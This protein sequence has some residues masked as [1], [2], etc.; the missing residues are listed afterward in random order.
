VLSGETLVETTPVLERVLLDSGLQPGPVVAEVLE[1]GNLRG[2]EGVPEGLAH[3][4]VTALEIPPVRH[5]EL[6]AAFQRHVDNSV[7]KTVN[8]PH[9]ATREDVAAIYRLA[10]ELQLKGVTV[11]RFGS[12]SAQVIEL[13]ALERPDRYLHG[14]K[15]DPE[16]CRL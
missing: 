3:L 7:S 15:C 10:W 11:Y 4:L 9:E 6:Q 13:G 8:L 5:L 12:R 2:V 16:E 14:T 1:K